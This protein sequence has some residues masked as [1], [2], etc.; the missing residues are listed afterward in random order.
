MNNLVKKV[1]S[2]LL[3]AV[4]TLTAIL[5]TPFKEKITEADAYSNADLFVDTAKLHDYI[6]GSSNEATAHYGVSEA[7]WCAMF[8]HLIA[9]RCG[10]GDKIPK[11]AYCDNQY[12]TVDG[13]QMDGYRSY[14]ER[15]GQFLDAK[16][17]L[18]PEI[19]DL[20]IFDSSSDFDGKGDHMG[21]VID[22]DPYTGLIYTI[23]GNGKGNKVTYEK[24]PY[25][26]SSIIGYCQTKLDSNTESI[27]P[28]PPVTPPEPVGP[29]APTVDINNTISWEVTNPEGC[30]IRYTPNGDVIGLILPNTI[31]TSVPENNQGEWIYV[32]AANMENGGIHDGYVHCSDVAPESDNPP[33]TTTAISTTATET[34]TTTAVSSTESTSSETSSETST[35]STT[36][37]VSESSA[38]SA[39]TTAVT[40]STT[41]MSTTT[42]TSAQPQAPVVPE[43]PTTATHYIS[44]LIGANGRITPEFAKD[45]IARIVDTDTLLIVNHYENGFAYCTLPDTGETYYIHQ[46]VM[47]PLPTSEDYYTECA[48]M[49]HYVSSDCGVNLRANGDYNGEILCILDTYQ[50]LSVLTSPN[51]LGFVFVEFTFGDGVI[52]N[53]YVHIDYITAY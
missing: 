45:N 42:A 25:F 39:S 32:K 28:A 7:P 36:S 21:I 30:N 12:Y 34:T 24:Y 16:D 43:Y 47:S 35:A 50:P 11:L 18:L 37:A 14:Y 17:Y 1:T 40:S 20:V 53:G 13:V 5:P 19:G 26:D 27:T 51:E 4:F 8:I 52:H 9:Y 15:I 46:S 38:T 2:I 49:S 41:V 23:E 33:V 10:L 48:R 3:S 29:E 22:I 44:C 31:L 6:S